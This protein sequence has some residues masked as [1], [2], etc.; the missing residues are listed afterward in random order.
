MPD[1]LLRCVARE[2]KKGTKK[3]AAW[4]ACV[5]RIGPKGLGYMEWDKKKGDWVLT[6][7][8][9]EYEKRRA[10]KKEQFQDVEEMILF[11]LLESCPTPGMKKRSK[12]QGQGLARGDGKGPLGDPLFRKKKKTPVFHS[13]ELLAREDFDEGHFT[14][15]EMLDGVFVRFGKL[16]DE[17]R[18]EVQSVSFDKARHTI[19]K[20]NAFMDQ[21]FPKR[22]KRS[23]KRAARK[24]STSS[25]SRAVLREAANDLISERIVVAG[26]YE[27]LRADIETALKKTGSYGKY[28]YVIATFPGKVIFSSDSEAPSDG[29]VYYSSTWKREKDGR[30]TFSDLKKVVR[31]VSYVEV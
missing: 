14:E 9:K 12:G 15:L 18:A 7:K 31:K 30:F 1:I 23:R 20:A 22:T 10:S 8:G 24:E 2:E 17:D 29:S 11:R 4:S 28:P 27:T 21:W 25:L 3:D 19:D 13:F 5:G 26:S 16:K 6:A